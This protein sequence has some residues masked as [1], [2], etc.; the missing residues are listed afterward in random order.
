MKKQRPLTYSLMDVM[1][2]SPTQATPS[3]ARTHQ[4]TRMNGGLHAMLR[5]DEPK[6]DDWR[7]VCDS[8]NLMETLVAQ[9]ILADA[10]GTLQQATEAMA[11]A[12]IRSQQGKGIRLDAPG[13]EVVRGVLWDYAFALENLPHRTMVICHRDT[14]KRMREIQSEKKQSHDVEVMSL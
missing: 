13:I 7:V 12:A 3:I 11:N 1:M 14:E 4:L 8:I 10:D 6:P 9:G 5:G 2:A